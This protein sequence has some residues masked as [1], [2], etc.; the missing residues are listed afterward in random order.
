VRN[1]KLTADGPAA[2]IAL[3]VGEKEVE[4]MAEAFAASQQ[5]GARMAANQAAHANATPSL[6]PALP[7]KPAVIRIE[8]LD[9]GTREIPFPGPQH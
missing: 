5:A 1:L 6:I 9:D 7:P 2:R 3:H 8:G 4:K